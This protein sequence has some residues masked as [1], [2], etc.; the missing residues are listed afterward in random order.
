MCLRGHTAAARP[1]ES[2][3]CCLHALLPQVVLY[4]LRS[5]LGVAPAALTPDAV[6]RPT[7]DAV[8][9]LGQLHAASLAAASAP[10]PLSLLC[11]QRFLQARRCVQHTA[12][13]ALPDRHLKACG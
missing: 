7:A 6:L 13:V 10:P 4:D 12:R 1:V 8:V 9:P 2:E 11:Q 3:R 5:P